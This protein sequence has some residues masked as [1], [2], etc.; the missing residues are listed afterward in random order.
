MLGVDLSGDE[1]A[2][3]HRRF[4]EAIGLCCIC[5]WAFLFLFC[6]VLLVFFSIA[7]S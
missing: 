4:E 2:E 3:A 5:F 6:F 7:D 1:V